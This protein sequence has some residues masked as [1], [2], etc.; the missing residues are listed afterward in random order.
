MS[1]DRA[2][3]IAVFAACVAALGA[4]SARAQSLRDEF[5]VNSAQATD[6]SPR[7]GNVAD[8]LTARFDLSDQWSVAVGGVATLEGKTPALQRGQFGTSGALIS[9]LSLGVDWDPTDHLSLGIA[10]D[11]SPSSTQYAGTQ[12]TVSN[13]GQPNR[14]ANLLVKS[15]SGEE[16]LGLDFGYD[17][18]GDS[19]AEWAFN[20]GVQLNNL[21]SEQDVT[22]VRFTGSPRTESKAALV[23]YCAS[24]PCGRSLKA[25]LKD[26]SISLQSIKLSAAGTLTAW[27]NTDFTLTG[28]YYGYNQDP[29]QLG[30]FSVAYAGRSVTTGGNGIPLA[31]LRYLIR[32]EA[33]HRFGDLSVRLYLQAGEYVSGAGQGTAGIGTKVQYK[34]SKK[35]KLWISLAGQTDTDDLG[36]QTNSGTFALGA[37]YRF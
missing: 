33:T 30:Y 3:P 31:P 8:A 6:A 26:T 25:A 22:A 29:T 18:A 5:S 35:F 1:L 12:L 10:F 7:S 21:S 17:T 13:P 20:T 14:D 27:V 15:I 28:D 19:D 2:T 16:N 11:L 24:H 37:G 4:S 23:T 36:N 9:T 34:F 32:P